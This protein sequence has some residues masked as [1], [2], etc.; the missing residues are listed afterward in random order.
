[1][2]CGAE[3]DVLCTFDGELALEEGDVKMGAGKWVAS[4]C[5]KVTLL[6]SKVGLMSCRSVELSEAGGGGWSTED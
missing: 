1:V 4:A 6:V 2:S 3:A 5:D